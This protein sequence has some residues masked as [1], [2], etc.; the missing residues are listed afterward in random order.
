MLTFLL[1]EDCIR[2]NRVCVKKLG[3]LCPSWCESS[4]GDWMHS[5]GKRL[6][7]SLHASALAGRA[8]TLT[9]ENEVGAWSVRAERLSRAPEGGVDYAF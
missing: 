4:D 6:A 9:M 7:A 3:L 2:K 5:K 1:P 8:L